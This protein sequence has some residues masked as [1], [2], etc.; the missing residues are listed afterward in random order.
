[1]PKVIDSADVPG[2]T[3]CSESATGLKTRARRKLARQV[4]EARYLAEARWAAFPCEAL[5][6]FPGKLWGVGFAEALLHRLRTTPEEERYKPRT[7]LLDA[8]K[9]VGR[10]SSLTDVSAP[11]NSGWAAY[12]FLCVVADLLE[13]ADKQLNLDAFF[14]ER[15]RRYTIEGLVFEQMTRHERT[16]AASPAARKRVP[17]R[18]RGKLSL[19]EGESARAAQASPTKAG[20]AGAA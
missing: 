7:A 19:V 11:L 13:I 3:R 18:R 15:I 5:D 17:A 20:A 6:V 9:E 2:A 10:I 12:A 8:L 16:H 1:M 14:R 4:A